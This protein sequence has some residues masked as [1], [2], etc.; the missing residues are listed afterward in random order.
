MNPATN[1]LVRAIDACPAGEVVVLPNSPDVILA[2]REAAEVSDKV[3]E[4]V[5]STS[6][7]AGV[8]ALVE[9]DPS[10]D[11]HANGE[12]LTEALAGVR[13]AAVAEA[14]RDD[15]EGRFVRGDAVGFAGEKIVAWGEASATLVATVAEVVD[16]AEI[17]TVIEGQDAPIPLDRL[18][19]KLPEGAE[20]ELHRGGQPSY[21]WLISAQ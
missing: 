10:L 5:E 14:A 12:R 9:F 13:S 6:P 8:A 15:A 11:A 16:G 4:V 3:V 1:D 2:A 19:L 18:P 21:W 17:V 7:Q 20:L